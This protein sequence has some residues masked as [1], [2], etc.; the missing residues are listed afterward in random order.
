MTMPS[1]VSRRRAPVQY[2]SPAGARDPKIGDA[3]HALAQVG[4]SDTPG[5]ALQKLRRHEEGLR[6]GVALLLAA[7]HGPYVADFLRDFDR[8][9]LELFHVK[10]CDAGMVSIETRDAA[11]DVS[12]L[13]WHLHRTPEHAVIALRDARRMIETCHEV[14]AAI[15]TE[16]PELS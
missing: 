7:G 5:G 10:L 13:R 15:L 3:G 1:T 2:A 4:Y 12:R 8:A 16:H 14:I 11:D 9:R 6:T